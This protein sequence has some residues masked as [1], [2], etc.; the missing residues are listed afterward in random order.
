M[1]F[2]GN[3][4]KD[5]GE[6][7]SSP[8]VSE[9]TKQ[10]TGLLKKV[11]SKIGSL[12]SRKQTTDTAQVEPMSNAGYLGEIYKL[13]VQNRDDARLET[14]KQV[15]RREEEDSEEQKRH[16]EIIKALT[17]R[18]RPKPKR[19]IRREK[20]AEEKVKEPPK[21]PVE[22]TK[23][24]KPAEPVKKP[25]EPT[26]PAEPVK[27]PA[28]PTKPAEPV[29]KPAEP[30]KPVE[31]PVEKP[32]A[33]P[34]K[35]EPKTAPKTK[36][37]EPVKPPQ[38][39]AEPVKPKAEP[40]KPKAEPVKPP[41]KAEPIKSVPKIPQLP[42]AKG[43]ALAA[44]VAAGLSS[45]AQANIMSQIES[46]SNFRPRSEDLTY[47]SAERIHKKFGK[48]RFP[49]VESAEPYVNNPEKLANYAYA[50]TDGNSEPGDG[51]KYRGRGFLQHTGKNQYKEISKYT[52]VDVLNNPDLLN[53]PAVAAKAIPWFFLKYK[54]KKPEQLDNI[55]VVNQAVGFA[56]GV[57]ESKKR[58]ELSLKYQKEISSTPVPQSTQNADKID[59]ASKE[60]KDMKKQEKSAGG[61][62][63][64][65]NVTNINNTTESSN[66]P[67]VD[68]RPAHQRK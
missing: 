54:N 27:K 53:D 2:F 43:V 42:G 61:G 6:S 38:P 41:T 23:P 66:A 12:L 5:T 57:E 18:R 13:M 45:K 37:A 29:K 39:K 59:V 46:E 55:S 65:V 15:N 14:E 63:G 40:V 22:P 32:K 28:E 24:S 10:S 1:K 17:I 25:A 68:D 44:L 8:V 35:A 51:W 30:T 7:S 52:G 50:K 31:K 16:S 47:S 49:T 48:K 67:I 36:P 33:E 58:E 21:K 4:K 26:K 64:F 20:K 11:T 34:V 19:V 56:G 3:N 9:K 60:N 62:R